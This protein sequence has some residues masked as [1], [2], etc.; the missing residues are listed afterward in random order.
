LDLLTCVFCI[1][2]IGYIFRYPNNDLLIKEIN[3]WEKESIQKIKQTLVNIAK[4]FIQYTNKSFLK[5]ENR[6]NEVAKP[7]KM[8]YGIRL[9]PYTDCFVR[10]GYI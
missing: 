3:K 10:P 4:T 6:L 5:I 7:V 1:L 9:L 8:P 2:Q